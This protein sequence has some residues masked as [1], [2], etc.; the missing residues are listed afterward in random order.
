MTKARI[1]MGAPVSTAQGL[2]MVM[3]SGYGRMVV[4]FAPETVDLTGLAPRFETLDRPNDRPLLIRAGE[5]LRTWSAEL[6]VM[7]PDP[8]DPIDDV[9]NGLVVLA[10]SA[11]PVKVAY[12]STETGSWRITD[13]QISVTDRQSGT[14]APSRATVTMTMTEASDVEIPAG[15]VTGGAPVPAA[16]ANVPDN[17]AASPSRASTGV[18]AA[19]GSGSRR[20]QETSS[21]D[22]ALQA[23]REAEAAMRAAGITGV[24]G[25]R[26]VPIDHG[27]RDRVAARAST[28][29]T[30]QAQQAARVGTV[31]PRVAGRQSTQASREAAAAAAARQ[32]A[33]D[34]RRIG[35]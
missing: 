2:R 17:D 18:R 35:Q 3:A 10:Q 24:G 34:A 20:P 6:P 15:P 5:Q 16:P 26:A 25:Q 29:A 1:R 11:Q 8:D 4:P 14:G 19:Q 22:R 12:G 9:L 23:R 30:R 13:L 27:G 31:N 7:R 28:L 32:R 21:A 33:I